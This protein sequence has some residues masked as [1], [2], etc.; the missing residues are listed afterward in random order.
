MDKNS[1]KKEKIEANL[2]EEFKQVRKK[3]ND[4]RKACDKIL[5]AAEEALELLT[6]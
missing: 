2:I 4:V 3:V 5:D 6:K 1:E